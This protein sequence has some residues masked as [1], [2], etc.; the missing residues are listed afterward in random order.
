MAAALRRGLFLAGS[1][2]TV[3]IGLGAAALLVP[4]L[5]I[6][7]P[8]QQPWLAGLIAVAVFTGVAGVLLVLP[9]RLLNRVGRPRRP[10]ADLPAG[11]SD[12]A[13][14]TFVERDRPTKHVRRLPT[15]LSVTAALLIIVLVPVTL[16]L[17]IRLSA[18]LGAPVR[19]TGFWPAVVAGLVFLAIQATA[20]RLL[21]V[22]TWRRHSQ[23][24]LLG[25]ALHLLHGAGLWLA[26]IA[27]GGVRLEPAPGIDQALTLVVLGIWIAA[28]KLEFAAPFLT[29]IA[30]VAGNALKLWAIAWLTTRM[31][32]TLTVHGFWTLVLASVIVTL[33][34]LPA[35]LVETALLPEDDPFPSPYSLTT[36][37]GYPY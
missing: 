6:G 18:Q 25:L 9:V 30:R 8:G 34:A 14:P 36:Y 4:G 33:V 12:R 23:W 31:E 32:V 26:V 37:G 27:L 35:W 10:A 11:E 20:S 5:Q 24:V 7:D 2:L 15:A 22:L 28:V 1:L 19:V 16:W 13:D 17:S 21:H 3:A 29:T